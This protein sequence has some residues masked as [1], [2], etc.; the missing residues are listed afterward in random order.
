MEV[1]IDTSNM[2]ALVEKAIFDSMTEEAIMSAAD[3]TGTF[4]QPAHDDVEGWVDIY[5]ACL[6]A[7]AERNED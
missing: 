6:G 7:T 4:D 1:K 3:N 5:A 2:Q